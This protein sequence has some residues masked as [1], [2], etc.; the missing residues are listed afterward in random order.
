MA[1]TYPP[2]GPT[3]TGDYETIHRL[4][5][6][7]TLIAKRLR[8]L[9]DERFI[10]DALLTGRFTANGGGVQ[11]EQ[12]DDSLY[13]DRDPEVV[14]P[15][16][17]YPL[18]GLGMGTT[19]YAEVQK[20]GQDVPVTDEA[21]KRLNRNPVDRAFVKLVNQ[22]VKKVDS[23]TMAAIVSAVTNTAA[24]AAVWS[25]ATAKQIFLDVA[26][27][28]ANI[29]DLGHGYDPDTVVLSTTAWTYAM[30][31]FADSG[32]LP[33]EDRQQ[34]VLTGMFP[35]IDG[36]RWLATPFVPV[37]N[38][39][40]VLDSTALGGMADEQLGG[41]G[42]AGGLGGIETKSIRDEENDKW[43]L[44]ARRVTVPVV[45]EPSSARTITGVTS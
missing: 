36:M 7:P 5:A 19:Q 10:A 14:R 39:A 22:L 18:A 41:P 26:T 42:Y 13:T 31:T 35:V 8:E 11:F 38:A 28:K 16:T 40:I 3:S 17:E 21:I 43:R 15:G 12:D 6:E 24:A 25:T 1:Y 23:V 32:Y 45:L 27:A 34:P 29:I 30:A 20:W 4:L 44:R 37:A 33:R 2:A 9:A